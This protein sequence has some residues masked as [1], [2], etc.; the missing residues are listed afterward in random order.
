MALAMLFYW[1]LP[2]PVV[3]A[4]WPEFHSNSQRNGQAEAN[5]PLNAALK[6]KFEG[7]RR[8][9]SAVVGKDGVLYAVGADTLYAISP[10]GKEKWRYGYSG[11]LIS[12]PAIDSEGVVYVVGAAPTPRQKAEEKAY[13]IAIYGHSGSV[14]WRAEAGRYR[15]LSVW[16]PHMAITSAG[17]VYVA[18]ENSLSAFN[19]QG[20]KEWTYQYTPD[21]IRG[22]P[23][24]SPDEKTIY[25]NGGG[26]Y[27]INHDGVLKWHNSFTGYGNS[28]A[29]V[30]PDG[31]VYLFDNA[32]AGLRAI[33]PEGKNK[34]TIRFPG[35]HVSSSSVAIGRDGTL[36]ADVANGSAGNG[37]A[38]HAI[39]PESGKVKWKFEIQGGYVGAALAVDMRGNLYYAAGNGSV[40]CLK[41]N[42]SLV[43][44]YSVEGKP[45]F[46][47]AS[48]AVSDE[49]IYAIEERTGVL[50]AI[51][52]EA[53][54]LP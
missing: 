12:I 19:A 50:F 33:T 38:I 28:P 43:Y 31:T 42:G 3:E 35:K 9:T 40:Y 14:K 13:L 22:V 29:T 6:W 11:G 39:N 2:C 48:P 47:S 46:L 32:E 8:G 36:Y 18:L 37:G 20:V 54:Q 30:A 53:G 51:G 25:I 24:L 5:G 21:G 26:L 10:D 34:W 16:L 41:P 44:R 45:R 7:L 15:L 27:A 17:R 52:A 4:F 1:L 23:S 49:T